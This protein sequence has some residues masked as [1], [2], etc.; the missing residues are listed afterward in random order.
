MITIQFFAALKDYFQEKEEW[1]LNDKTIADLKKTLSKA[2]P[3]AIPVLNTCRFA[4]NFTFVNDNYLINDNEIIS[5]I[6][7]AGGG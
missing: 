4:V 5:I 6:P 7:P 1:P 2:K 3:D